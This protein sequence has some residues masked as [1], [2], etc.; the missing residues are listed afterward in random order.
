MADI[1]P[2]ACDPAV[3]A[4]AEELVEQAG[5]LALQGFRS[6]DLDTQRKADGTV[7]T[8]YDRA[9]E[10]LLRKGIASSFPDDGVLG[11]EEVEVAGTS[12][13]RWILDPIDGTAPYSRGI[14]TWG[15]LVAC[16]DRHGPLL[17]IAA[18]PW[19]DETVSAGRGIG[20]RAG[21]HRAQV[22]GR[23]S[24]EGALL[25]TSGIEWWPPGSFERVTA[26][27]VTVRTWGNVYGLVLATSGRVDAV[28]DAGVKPW[29]IAPAPTL[30]TEAGGAF[31]TLDGSGSIHSGSAL[32]C[33]EALLEP[34]LALLRG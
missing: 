22:S 26:A 29:D 9:V 23:A 20:C 31:A 27:G 24:L 4:R 28:F 33:G 16:E 15:V 21:G 25:V 30:G 17:G 5:A 8:A 34:L 14:V 3:L 1:A 12:G 18:C 2:P 11:E 7:V 6:G 10:R 13:R 19:A 32:L